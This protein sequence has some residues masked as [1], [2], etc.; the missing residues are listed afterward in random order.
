MHR[1]ELIDIL[2]DNPM[3]LRDLALLL[4]QSP[5]DLE[6]DLAHLDRS[7]RH[8][9]YRLEVQPAECRQC[10]FVFRRDKLAKPGKCPR[11]KGTW[12]RAPRIGIHE[13]R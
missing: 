2:R 13:D 3:S 10:G 5:K 7:L 1:K 4:Q 6:S 9:P 12:I 8:T 11:C